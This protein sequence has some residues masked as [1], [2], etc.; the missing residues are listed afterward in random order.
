MN[1]AKLDWFLNSLDQAYFPH[2][3]FKNN[4]CFKYKENF[5]S[6]VQS[7]LK[8]LKSAEMSSTA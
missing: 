1:Q 6:M 4:I 3:I 8:N 2:I 7:G 5:E